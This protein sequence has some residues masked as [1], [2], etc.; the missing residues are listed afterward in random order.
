ME[1]VYLLLLVIPVFFLLSIWAIGI[2]RTAVK[3]QRQAIETQNLSVERQKEAL[4][5]AAEA[6]ALSR[7][8]VENQERIIALLEEIRDKTGSA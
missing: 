1:A 2:Q 6:I 5:H 7:R 3:R 8:Q 4:A